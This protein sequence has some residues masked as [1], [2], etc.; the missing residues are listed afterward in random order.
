MLESVVLLIPSLVSPI[1]VSR[2]GSGDVKAIRFADGGVAAEASDSM[3]R[4]VLFDVFD[5]GIGDQGRLTQ[6]ALALA[7]LALKQV[8]GTLTTT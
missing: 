8:T 5:V 2:M 6:P 4:K 7:V 1:R 3:E